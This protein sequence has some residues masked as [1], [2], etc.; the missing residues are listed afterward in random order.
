MFLNGTQSEVI[1]NRAILWAIL[2]RLTESRVLAAFFT[3]MALWCLLVALM[4][5]DE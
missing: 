3:A 4:G 5:V 1:F 2:V